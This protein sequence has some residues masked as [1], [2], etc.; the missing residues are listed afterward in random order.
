[1]RGTT[2]FLRAYRQQGIMDMAAS[3]SFYTIISIF[4]LMILLVSLASFFLSPETMGHLIRQFVEENLPHQSSLIMQNVSTLARKHLSFGW[5]GVILLFF[6]AQVLYVNFEKFINKLLLTGKKRHFLMT[7]LFFLVWLVVILTVLMSPLVF[8]IFAAQ[9][10]AISIHLGVVGN[11]LR[12]GGSVLVNVV[13]FLCVAL[14]LPTERPRLKRVFAGAVFFSLA[15]FC[16]KALFKWFTLQSLD[17]YN[18]IYGSLGSIV[19]IMVW[20]F[21]FYNILLATTFWV[22]SKKPLG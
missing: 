9:L 2:S 17:R 19:L 22:G 11:F 13:S 7:R 8:E 15:L 4:P 5:L 6:S 10:K 21:Y 16:G 12:Q 20:I 18:I 14:I 3:L 1:M